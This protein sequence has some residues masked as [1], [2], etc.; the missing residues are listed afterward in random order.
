LRWL[1]R[2]ARRLN[3]TLSLHI[4]MADAYKQSPLFDEYVSKDCFA[5]DA[6]GQ[7]LGQTG[8]WNSSWAL[9]SRALAVLRW[10]WL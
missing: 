2:E 5:K 8:D 3:T 10:S 9:G 7:P 1:I 6:S 4:N